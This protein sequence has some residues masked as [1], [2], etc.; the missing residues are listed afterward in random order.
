MKAITIEVI[1]FQ[2]TSGPQLKSVTLAEASPGGDPNATE[3][4]RPQFWGQERE[5]RYSQ[6][7]GHL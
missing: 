7:E 3:S 1:L 5:H 6:T 2:V 4:A